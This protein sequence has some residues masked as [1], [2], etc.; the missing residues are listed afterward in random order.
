M[1]QLQHQASSVG[2]DSI[3]TSPRRRL[4]DQRAALQIVACTD[5]ENLIHDRCYRCN[6]LAR[7]VDATIGRDED[8]QVET[9]LLLLLKMMMT[10]MMMTQ[11][12][13]LTNEKQS[14]NA[15]ALAAYYPIPQSCQ[16]WERLLYFRSLRDD[17]SEGLAN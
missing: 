10:Q 5:Q 11:Q 7:A 14:E 3:V 1:T 6:T 16:S 17:Q 15:D 8:A 9:M 13:C 4:N 2:T 12:S